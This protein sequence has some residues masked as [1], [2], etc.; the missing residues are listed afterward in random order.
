MLKRAG[1]PIKI[2]TDHRNL[3]YFMT[4]KQLSRR[5]AHWSEY[6]SR[7]NFVIQFC[8]GKLGAKPDALTK[9][10][11]DLPK[12]E[13]ERIKQ[14]MQIVLKKHNLDLA[15]KSLEDLLS[16]S[17]FPTL[18]TPSTLSTLNLDSTTLNISANTD[19]PI[20]VILEDEEAMTLDQ[21]L[22]RGYEEDPIPN[23]VLELL[24]QA[25]NYSRN[26]TIADC[27]NINGRLHY[28]RLLYVPDY[29]ALQMHLC[30]LH[31]DIPIAGHL[32]I[33]NTYKLLHRS[34]YWPD[35]QGFV[36]RY[37]R[38]CHVCKKSKGSCFKK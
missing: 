16:D 8:P 26:L 17:H 15:I 4:T 18:P 24:A 13:D 7:F 10:S 2:L 23:R 9:R 30:K 14:I 32:G 25:A 3:Q 31:H 34:Y 21:L 22:N 29:H 33:G 1:L 20:E 12:T 28:R 6:L 37:V 11:R 27:S 35:M 19:E 36:R 5:Q 38:H